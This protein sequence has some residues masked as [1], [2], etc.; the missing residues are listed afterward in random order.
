MSSAASSAPAASFDVVVLGAGPAGLSS[1]LGLG[2]AVRSVLVVDSAVY[3][4]ARAE[5]MHNVLGS[6]GTPPP[7]FKAHGRSQIEALYK[8]V[9]FSDNTQVTA[10]LQRKEATKEDEAAFPAKTQLRLTLQPTSG[11]E[12]EA[13]S[14]PR[15]V[16]Y[17]RRMILAVGM[18][19]QPPLP[20]IPGYDELWG[21]LIASCPYCHGYEVRGAV[22]AEEA[23]A[24][25][26]GGWALLMRDFQLEHAAAKGTELDGWVSSVPPPFFYH[27]TTMVASFNTG[28]GVPPLTIFTHGQKASTMFSPEQLLAI[29]RNG[30]TI[31]EGIVAS[32]TKTAQGNLAVTLADSAGPDAKPLQFKAMFT[33]GSTVPPELVRSLRSPAA[34]AGTPEAPAAAAGAAAPI[35][36]HPLFKTVEVDMMGKTSVPNIYA[37]GDIMEFRSSVPLALG[38]GVIAAAGAN[39]ELGVED[40]NAA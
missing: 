39:G 31:H 24:G 27:Y 21:T 17:A 10:V 4:N 5:H 2:R 38:S 16:V 3:R 8:T 23:G 37:A 20:T 35:K 22:P 6:D 11:S 28:A 15:R 34:T 25:G 32:M 13:V 14:E 30:I 12:S 36:V 40:F 33:R 26:A 9:Q 1:A 19:D 18:V 29:A 7:E